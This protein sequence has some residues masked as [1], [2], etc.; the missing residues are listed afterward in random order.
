M[1][2]A[3]AAGEAVVWSAGVAAAAAAARA[4]AVPS[5][6]GAVVVVVFEGVASEDGA[7]ACARQGKPG[8][9]TKSSAANQPSAHPEALVFIYKNVKS[10]RECL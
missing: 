7:V 4:A 5:V 2:G 1:A 10:D 6:A 9:K 8:L 3:V